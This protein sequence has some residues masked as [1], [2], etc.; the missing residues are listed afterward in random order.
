MLRL[1]EK[2]NKKKT[3]LYGKL[4]LE[5]PDLQRK[6]ENMT[7]LCIVIHDVMGGLKRVAQNR[8]ELSKRHCEILFPR[9]EALEEQVLRENVGDCWQDIDFLRSMTHR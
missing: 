4:V 8:T 2:R 6:I 3:G 7:S 9:E 1:V 5:E